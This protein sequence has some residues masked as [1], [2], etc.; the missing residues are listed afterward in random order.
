MSHPVSARPGRVPRGLARGLTRGLTRGRSRAAAP[1][2][3][4]RAW[5]PAGPPL[6]PVATSA[7]SAA[8]PLSYPVGDLTKGQ[9][10]TGLT[11][12][13]G[14]EPTGFTGEVLGV[15]RDGI[16]PGLDMVMARL[17][18]PEIDRVGGIW[19]GMSGS[20]VYAADG[21]LIG[22]VSYGL[23]VGPSP[24]AGITPASEM[25]RMLSAA[26]QDPQA[27][28]ADQVDIP[29]T[30]ATRMVD[31]GLL[32]REEVSEGMTRLPVPFGISG[33]V[34]AKR[35][36]QASKAFGLSG[37]H[38]Y[39]SGSVTAADEAIPV[40]AGGNIAASMSYGDVSS[41]GVGTV[42]AV[43]GEEVLAFGHPMNFTGPSHMTMHGADAV[44]IQEDPVGAPF[45]MANAGAPVGVISQDRLAGIFG[46]QSAAAVPSTTRVTSY[47]E[48]PGDWSR[49]GTTQVS[50]PDAV[51][52]I[53]AFH[54]LADQDRVFD[55]MGKGTAQVSWTIRG[56]RADGRAFAFTRADKFASKADLS[57][58]PA[59]DLYDELAQIHFTDAE[60]VTLDSIDTRSTMSREYTAYSVAKV[61]VLIGRRWEPLG[62]DRPLLLHPGMTKKFRVLLDSAA[63]GQAWVPV[64]LAVPENL[65]H[66]SGMLDILGGNSFFPAGQGDFAEEGYLDTTSPETFEGLLRRLQQAPHNDQV[67]ANL[68]VF[69][70]NGSTF[71][72]TARTGTR[73]VVEGGVTVEVMGIPLMPRAGDGMQGR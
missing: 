53:A 7:P 41:I 38:V 20:P 52:D 33:M 31:T 11:V 51:P 4:F 68:T 62:T 30:M 18:S 26:P 9:A 8:C 63:L 1:T 5:A 59:F 29:A 42:T 54:L 14:T 24:V 67:L 46:L 60:E 16:G 73:A 44:Y 19:Q 71:T 6:A 3:G 35:L 15:I 50:V 57:S 28:A 45:K 25:Y 17:T 47:V 2:R 72:R 21:R 39:R 37:A 23:S 32:A 49:T 70:R 10:V 40:A 12:T 27:Q 61:R 34:S 13:S 22:A 69:R 64:N 66:K 36:A 55:G 65:G 43:C 56:H 48:V 58:E